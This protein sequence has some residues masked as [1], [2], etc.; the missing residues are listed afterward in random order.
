M[1]KIK[2]TIN[3]AFCKRGNIRNEIGKLEGLRK[4]E[5]KER[6]KALVKLEQSLETQKIKGRAG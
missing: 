4:Q 2:S 1:S 6:L 3:C 5:N